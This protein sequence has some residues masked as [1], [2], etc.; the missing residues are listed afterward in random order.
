MSHMRR[1][2]LHHII[3]PRP[4]SVPDPTASLCHACGSDAFVLADSCHAASDQWCVLMR[5]GDCGQWREIVASTRAMTRFAAAFDAGL[6]AIE[7][8]IRALEL[9]R[10]AGEVD[11]FVAALERDLIDAS[12]FIS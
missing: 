12:D 2:L 7:R 4:V 9:E 11:V 5:C 6:A 1:N 8:D 3:G 10:M